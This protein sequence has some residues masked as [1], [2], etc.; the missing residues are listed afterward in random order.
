MDFC[1]IPNIYK[2]IY[3]YTGYLQKKWDLGLENKFQ[4]VTSNLDGG[5]PSTFLSEASKHLK[6]S[7]KRKSHF[8]LETPCI[9]VHELIML[10]IHT[11]KTKIFPN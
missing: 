9:Y 6:A 11:K 10:Y 3:E 5:Q 4:C 7:S 2:Y 8:F 1:H